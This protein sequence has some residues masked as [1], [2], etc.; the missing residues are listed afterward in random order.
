VFSDYID[1]GILYGFFHFKLNYVTKKIAYSF[2]KPAGS[3]DLK[4]ARRFMKHHAGAASYS[5]EK[6]R[7]NIYIFIAS[8]SLSHPHLHPRPALILTLTRS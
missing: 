8:L 6:K 5:K 3:P 7:A 2:S 4:K 1:S